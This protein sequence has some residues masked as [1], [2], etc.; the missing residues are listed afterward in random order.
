MIFLGLHLQWHSVMRLDT[1]STK[2][3]VSCSLVLTIRGAISNVIYD[4]T[5]IK[6]SCIMRMP[7]YYVSEQ[8][9]AGI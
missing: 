8:I 4:S 9:D 5:V 3:A 1:A 2:S 7:K 6:M